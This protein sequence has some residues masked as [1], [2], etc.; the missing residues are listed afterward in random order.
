MQLCTMVVTLK[1]GGLVSRQIGQSHPPLNIPLNGGRGKETN[2]K[3]GGA[4]TP[5]NN[6]G[7][8]V[9]TNHKVDGATTLNWMAEEQE[10]E[11]YQGQTHPLHTDLGLGELWKWEGAQSQ[12]GWA[13]T[14]SL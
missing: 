11:T 10:E 4:T 8:G 7:R 2:L 13:W 5:T 3:M 12:G 6:E 9:E 14:W 1:G